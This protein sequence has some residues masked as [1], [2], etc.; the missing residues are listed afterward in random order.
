LQPP[1]KIIGRG[2]PVQNFEEKKTE[3][4]MA[5]KQLI[6]A[7]RRSDLDEVGRIFNNGADP[8]ATVCYQFS[9]LL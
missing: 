6:D 1:K 3:K 9:N 4:K 7:I 8:N 2:P 5:N